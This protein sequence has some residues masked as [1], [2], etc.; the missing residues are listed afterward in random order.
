M[1]GPFPMNFYKDL[2]EILITKYGKIGIKPP[3]GDLRIL[4]KGYLNLT[5]KLI[6]IKRRNVKVS[7]ELREKDFGKYY[8]CCLHEIKNKFKNGKDVNRYLSKSA[9]KPSKRDLLLYD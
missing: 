2:L 5:D 1:R 6:D 3:D 7:N 9:S 8:N 4:L